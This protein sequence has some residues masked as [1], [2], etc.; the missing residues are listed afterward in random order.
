[1]LGLRAS[2]SKGYR[3]SEIRVGFRVY[4]LLFGF[5]LSSQDVRLLRPEGLGMGLIQTQNP[6]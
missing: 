5:G 6:K 3:T 4:G 1:M 2:G